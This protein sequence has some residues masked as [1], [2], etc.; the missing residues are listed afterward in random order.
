LDN[1]AKKLQ[2]ALLLK[3][4]PHYVQQ[5][6]VRFHYPAT[7]RFGDSST[8]ASNFTTLVFSECHYFSSYPRVK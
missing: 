8:Y 6:S 4:Q 3:F 5:I 1:S 7:L 2:C